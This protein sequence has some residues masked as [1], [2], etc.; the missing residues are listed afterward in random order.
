MEQPKPIPES[1]L[2]HE[3]SLLPD[4]PNRHE[5]PATRMLKPFALQF[6]CQLHAVEPIDFCI[7]PQK[8]FRPGACALVGPLTKS[9]AVAM[10]ERV[11]VRMEG[12]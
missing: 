11:G 9:P 7:H 8:K 4:Q 5:L 2:L 6:G 3:F 10:E 12:G 1:L